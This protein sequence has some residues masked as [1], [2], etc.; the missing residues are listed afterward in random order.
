MTP[1]LT[2]LL[3]LGTLPKPSI[4]AEPGSVVPWGS[5]VTIWCQGTLEAAEFYLD[6]DGHS[7][8][9][10]RQP[11][12]EPRDKA[13]F[14]I[15]Y[16]TE[17]YAGQ[18]H[19]YY[20]SPTGLSERSDPLELVVT[21]FH[22]KPTLSAL[23]NPMVSS[24][25]KV[26]LQCASWVGFHRFVLMKEGEPRPTWTLDSQRRTSGQFQALFPVGPVTPRLRWTFRCYGY[27]RNT[28]HMWSLSSDPLEL[29]VSGTSGGPSPPPTDPS[30]TAGAADT[31]SPSQNKSD[32][33]TGA[34]QSERNPRCIQEVNS[35]EN[36]ATIR[37]TESGKHILCAQ[38]FLE[39][40]VRHV[41]WELSTFH[42]AQT[43][44]HPL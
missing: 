14:S 37:M 28:P 22:G 40:Y 24:G 10:D 33:N 25:G 13:K 32:H 16:M 36:N 21:G 11:A 9:W 42:V 31:I 23:P 27:F 34:L 5:A 39:E 19:C 2:A 43:S 41:L 12:V 6:K 30:S 8:P 1:T 18:Y 4:W 26:T 44:P 3:L 38:E 15:I 29:L 17:Q 35:R 7:V 20:R